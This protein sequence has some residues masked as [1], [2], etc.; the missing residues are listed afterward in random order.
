[1]KPL[2]ERVVVGAFFVLMGWLI[3]LAAFGIGPM[4]GAPT[5]AP[6][7]VIGAAGMVFANGGLLVLA[8]ARGVALV[9]GGIIVVGISVIS[10]WIALFG[11]AQ[12][13][14]GG[15]S[16]FSRSVEVLIARLLFG[17]V[18]VLGLAISANAL[19]KVWVHRVT[20]KP[21]DRYPSPRD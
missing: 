14:S 20:G 16:W 11:D 1:M 18:A 17:A 12:Y 13:F 5:H 3:L 15:M 21:Q 4:A 6:R 9:G 2:L 19:R 10:A 7:W 8:P